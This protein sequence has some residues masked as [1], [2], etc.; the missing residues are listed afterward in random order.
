MLQTEK[1]DGKTGFDFRLSSYLRVARSA[2]LI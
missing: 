1:D 2:V